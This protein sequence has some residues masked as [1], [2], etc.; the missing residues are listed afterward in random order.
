MHSAQWLAESIKMFGYPE[1]VLK[2]DGE[3][4][5]IDLKNRAREQCPG[6]KIVFEES[7]VG[8]SQANGAIRRPIGQW[9]SS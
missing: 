1:L 7:P 2:S 5:I 6:V 3:P 9:R 4:A 8:D